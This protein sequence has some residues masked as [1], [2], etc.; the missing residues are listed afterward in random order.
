MRNRVFAKRSLG[1][2][3]LVDPNFQRKIVEAVR[4]HYDGQTVLEIGPGQG[5]LTHHLKTFAHKLLLVEKDRTLAKSLA[6]DFAC[7]N[8]EVVNADFLEWDLSALPEA[9]NTTV[10][11]N[12]PY[13]VSTQ[14]LIRLLQ[15]MQ[16]FSAL[17]LMFQKEVAERCVAKPQSR[18]LKK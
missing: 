15:Q 10:I 13:N 5:A 16:Q 7:S 6:D 17:I 4:V 1:Q 12:L 2:N 3:F 9:G 18:N 8:T 11:A 14:I